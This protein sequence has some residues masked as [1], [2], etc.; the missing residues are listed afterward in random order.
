MAAIL[1][2]LFFW[3]LWQFRIGLLEH[4]ALV[5]MNNCQHFFLLEP[6]FFYL[7]PRLLIPGVWEVAVVRKTVDAERRPLFF[8]FVFEL[9]PHVLGLITG[10]ETKFF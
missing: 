10:M 2:L 7:K 5:S 8:V 1:A 9:S 4:T 6:I 3:A